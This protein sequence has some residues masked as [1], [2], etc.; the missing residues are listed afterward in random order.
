MKCT[1]MARFL[2]VLGIFGFIFQV[3]C[4]NQYDNHTLVRL[5]PTL[6]V[7]LNAVK[8]FQ[9]PS[10]EVSVLK[11]SRGVNDTLDLLVPPNKLGFVHDYAK[12][13]GLTL[14]E[15]QRNYGRTLEDESQRLPRR[16]VLRSFNIF[17]Y[18]SFG[19]IQG[20]LE[21]LAH[22]FPNLVQ[23]QELGKSFE[24]RTMKLVKI[25]SQPEAGN[26][27]IFVDAGIHSREWVAPAMATYLISRLATDSDSMQIG[28]ILDGVDWYILPVVNPDGYEYSRS[29]ANKRLWRKTR[30]KTTNS[31]CYGVDG[32]RN[33]GFKWAVSGVSND[34]CH[35]ETF[36][37]N[38]AF[39]EPETRMVSSVMLDNKQRIKL[40][41]SLHSY[42]QYLVYP[43]GYT[44]D[45]LPKQWKKLDNMGKAVSVAVQRAGGK[46]FKVMSAGKWY[47][48]AGGSDDF[49]YGAAGIPYSY[50]M[51]L[52]EGYEFTFPESLLSKTLPQVYEGFKEFGKRIKKEF[53]R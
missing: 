43:W 5:H 13:N 19:A 50:T 24:G 30:S 17:G 20:Y 47:P 41:V 35:A 18:N 28:G 39:S 46:P 32:N 31:R 3:H 26:P 11:E 53:G 45:Y 2:I 42:G 10:L 1:V 15:K 12:S 14:E 33:Y 38:K 29:S 22:K 6:P 36:A 51:E 40:Y 7:H 34:P 16:R 8:T 21:E 27:V 48:A 37:G 49:A 52:T 25:S 23:L 44:G 9:D 4:S